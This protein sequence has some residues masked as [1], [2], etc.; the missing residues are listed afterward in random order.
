MD[1]RWKKKIL[2]HGPQVDFNERWSAEGNASFKDG[3]WGR[4]RWSAGGWGS[5]GR[6]LSHTKIQFYKNI[7]LV[8]RNSRWVTLV[9]GKNLKKPACSWLVPRHRAASHAPGQWEKSTPLCTR[10]PPWASIS[11][12]LVTSTF[13]HSLYAMEY[14]VSC[15]FGILER[16]ATVRVDMYC[17]IEPPELHVIVR[18]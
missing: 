1:E 16:A 9:A 4:G 17:N 18:G 13:D 15:R 6:G 12:S 7:G 14:N 3:R 8:M 10:L 2:L 11:R 5:Q